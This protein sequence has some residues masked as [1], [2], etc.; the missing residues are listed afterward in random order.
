M[1]VRNLATIHGLGFE[2]L[3]RAAWKP[4]NWIRVF[5]L[6]P[7]GERRV[8]LRRSGPQLDSF[9]LG[10]LPAKPDRADGGRILDIPRKRSISVLELFRRG[11]GRL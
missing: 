10:I 7:T 3:M 1:K 4:G 8:L 6:V 11:R 9:R 2:F 5:E